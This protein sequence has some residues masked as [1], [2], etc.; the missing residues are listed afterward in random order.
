MWNKLFS[1]HL[2]LSWVGN[3][4]EAVRVE[5]W[6]TWDRVAW[7]SHR[8]IKRGRKGALGSITGVHGRFGEDTTGR[9]LSLH[10]RNHS[11]VYNILLIKDFYL[12]RK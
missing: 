1:T 9:E 7:I 6:W 2:S 3:H 12:I 8:I 10:L 4:E 11:G 5:R